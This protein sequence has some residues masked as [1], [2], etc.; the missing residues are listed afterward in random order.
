L[1]STPVERPA[2][3]IHLD[4]SVLV[5]ALTGPRRSAPALRRVLDRGERIAIAT[6]VLYEWLRGPRHEAELTYQEGLLPAA[7][8]LPFGPREAALAA[9]LYRTVRRGRQREFDLGVAACAL[10]S[11]A[12]LWTLDAQDFRDIPGLELF[13]A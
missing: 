5:D 8:A 4:T 11:G 6:L 1:G 2:T 9:E 3:V 13:E 7:A 12:A 10:L